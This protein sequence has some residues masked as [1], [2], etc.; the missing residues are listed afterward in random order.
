L[1]MCDLLKSKVESLEFLKK[2][3]G[4]QKSVQVRLC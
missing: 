4:I 1:Q 3:E 2:L